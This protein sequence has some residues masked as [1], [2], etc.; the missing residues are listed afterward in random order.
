MFGLK[1]HP[2]GA[3]KPEGEKWKAKVVRGQAGRLAYSK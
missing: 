2:N 3:A 1:A